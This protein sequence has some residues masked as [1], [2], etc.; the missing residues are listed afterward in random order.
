MGAIVFSFV[1]YAGT[2]YFFTAILVA[3]CFATMIVLPAQADLP[4]PRANG[5]EEMDMLTVQGNVTV[6]QILRCRSALL[7][8]MCLMFIEIFAFFYEPV[9]AIR[10][11]TGFEMDSNNIGY[12]FAVAG[13]TYGFGAVMVGQ[14]CNKTNRKYLVLTG[15]LILSLGMFLFG[16]SKT[17]GFPNDLKVLMS[18]FG[19]IGL[20]LAFVT[21]PVIPEVLDTVTEMYHKENIASA[22]LN[23]RVAGLNATF[24]GLGQMIAPILGGSLVDSLGFKAA[25]DTIAICSLFV[26]VVYFCALIL[27]GLLH[28]SEAELF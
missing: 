6:M 21:I 14:I 10:L 1:G 16:P 17:M 28:V 23:D 11:E 27:P 24:L 19:L 9:L 8:L 5:L 15:F 13:V 22:K 3:G 4:E 2:F 20:S 25:T 12:V 7:I 18:G 26:A